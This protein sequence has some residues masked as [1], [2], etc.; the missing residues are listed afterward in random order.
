MSFSFL[1]IVITSVFDVFVI[2]VKHCISLPRHRYCRQD[3]G[4][5]HKPH[6]VHFRYNLW[7]NVSLS[8]LLHIHIIQ[9]FSIQYSDSKLEQVFQWMWMYRNRMMSRCVR[10][11]M[12]ILI[13]VPFMQKRLN[14]LSIVIN[15]PSKPNLKT[16]NWTDWSILSAMKTKHSEAGRRKII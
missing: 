12:M 14:F 1:L 5:N 15:P 7:I 2:C 8:R 6:A 16:Q 3:T 11:Y 10:I 13:M 9:T 4:L